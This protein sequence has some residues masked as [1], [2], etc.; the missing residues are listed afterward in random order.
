MEVKVSPKIKKEVSGIL[1]EYGYESEKDFIEDALWRRILELKKA[2]FL[3][4]IREIREKMR[5]KGLREEDILK[6][7]EKLRQL[8]K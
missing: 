5:K 6:D 1:K 4:K 8:T 7:F 2:D 3:S